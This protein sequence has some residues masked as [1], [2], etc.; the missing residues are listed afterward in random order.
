MIPAIRQ[1]VITRI[2]AVFETE[3]ETNFHIIHAY[4]HVFKA[5]VVSSNFFTKSQRGGVRWRAEQRDA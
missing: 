1:G 2:I 4:L 5:R 3:A